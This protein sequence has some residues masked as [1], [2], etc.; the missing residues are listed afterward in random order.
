MMSHSYEIKILTAAV[1]TKTELCHIDSCRI[2]DNDIN[3]QGYV[4][5]SLAQMTADLLSKSKSLLSKE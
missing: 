3:I 2:I 1:K 4:F 5:N